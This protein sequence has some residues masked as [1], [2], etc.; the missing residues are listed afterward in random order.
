MAGPGHWRVLQFPEGGNLTFELVVEPTRSGADA[1]VG[2][3][4]T[5][6]NPTFTALALSA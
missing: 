2:G 4:P 6:R 5:H 3:L 1:T